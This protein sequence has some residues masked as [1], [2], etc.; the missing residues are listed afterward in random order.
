[1]SV[2]AVL[3]SNAQKKEDISI[4]FDKDLFRSIS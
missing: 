2:N 1:M 4:K 3:G